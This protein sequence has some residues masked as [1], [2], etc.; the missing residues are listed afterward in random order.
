M[1]QRTRIV[2]LFNMGNS[3]RAVVLAGERK[4]KKKKKKK[5]KVIEGARLVR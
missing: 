2:P 5:K 1:V 4:K 3:T